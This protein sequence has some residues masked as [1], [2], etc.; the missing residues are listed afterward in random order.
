MLISDKINAAFN[1]QIGHEFYNSNLYLAAASYFDG[2]SL[3]G[4]AK[5]YFKQADEEHMHGM[6]FVHFI[7]EAGGKVE[8]PAIPAPPSTFKSAEEAAQLAYDTEIHTTN[9]IYSLVTLAIEE[10]NYIAQNFL[11]WFVNEQLE[12]VSSAQTNLDVI[13]K[14]G[15]NL[16]TVEAYLAH[17]NE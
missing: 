17:A 14:A 11:Q 9:L 2:E 6:K 15:S 12:E 1:A 5:L 13:K 10:K 4:L 3:K 7:L 8:V 16:L